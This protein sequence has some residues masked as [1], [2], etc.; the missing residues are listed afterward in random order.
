MAASQGEVGPMNPLQESAW[1]SGLAEGEASFHLKKSKRGR[2]LAVE[3]KIEMTD[4][5]VVERAASIAGGRTQVYE[6]SSTRPNT[7]P[8]YYARWYGTDAEN[9][10]RRVLPYMGKRRSAKI[11]EILRTPNLSHH[12]R[13]KHV[14]D[15]VT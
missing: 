13:R 7:K 6:R 11:N 3:V 14:E 9:F 5:D 2:Q 8:I 15:T 12:P 4:K 1:L 10:M